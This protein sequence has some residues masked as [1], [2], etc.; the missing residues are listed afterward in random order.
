MD[1]LIKNTILSKNGRTDK[2][3]AIDILIKEGIITNIA[4]SIDQADFEI[5]DA[6]GAFVSPGWVE[7]FSDFADPGMEYRE[8]LKTGAAAAFSGG[9]TRVFLVPNTNPVVDNK[10]Q[11]SYLVEKSKSLPVQILPIGAISKGACGNELAEMYDMNDS[12]AIAFSDGKY[13]V[14]SPGLFLK[15]LQYVK[16]CDSVLIQQPFD[17]TIGTHGLIN[18]GIVSTRLG[19][20]GLPAIA[21]ELMIQRDIELVRYTESKV[22]F[23]GISAAKSVALIKAAKAEGLNVTCSVTPQHLLFTDEDLVTYDVNLKINPP[24][25]TPIDRDALRAGVLDGT[26]DIIATHH[27]P[28]HFDDKVKE[29]EYAK[30]G[31]IGLQTTY[32]ALMEA[33][34]SLTADRIQDLLSDN[35]VRIFGLEVLEIRIGQKA[36]LTLFDPN[37]SSTFTKEGNKSKAQNSPYFDRQFKGAV[38]A[39]IAHNQIHKN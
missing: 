7:I 2:K 30:N 13:P 34:P 6:Q 22:H 18:E 31:M 4:P 15:A 35:A 27:F 3:S 26:I 17:K 39:T 20:P 19:L 32:S 33:L 36:N 24:L 9:F 37:K 16:T 12:G 25:R 29:F 5:L 23:T 1:I 28:Q 8:V 11:V 38:I 10:S 14:Q 21:E